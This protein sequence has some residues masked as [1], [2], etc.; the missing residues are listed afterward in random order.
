MKVGRAATKKT[1]AAAASPLFLWSSESCLI[2][3]SI[4]SETIAQ[5][6][7]AFFVVHFLS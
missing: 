2:K 6:D 3:M 5:K 1:F 4:V 7:V